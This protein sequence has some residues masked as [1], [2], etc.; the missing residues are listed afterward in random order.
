MIGEAL[1]KPVAGRDKSETHDMTKSID[2]PASRTVVVWGDSI[3][4]SGW[5][6]LLETTFNVGCN[7]GIPLRVVNY[8]NMSSAL[9]HP[10]IPYTRLIADDGVHLSE[11]GK[12][13]FARIAATELLRIQTSQPTA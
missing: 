11:L 10:D 12:E 1:A 3:A 9:Q 6:Q 7:T 8:V 4:A 5:P 2:K 13:C